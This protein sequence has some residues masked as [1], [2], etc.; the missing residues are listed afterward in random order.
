MQHVYFIGGCR[1]RLS[2]GTVFIALHGMQTRYSDE[3]AGWC[4]MGFVA[5]FLENTTVKAVGK[6]ANIYES[7][8]RKYSG[9]VF[10]THFVHCAPLYLRTLWRYTNAVIIITCQSKNCTILFLNNFCQTK[11]YCDNLGKAYA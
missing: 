8:E 7:Y 11:V 3:K 9:T 4:N 10:L 5:N 6:S 1:T 2:V